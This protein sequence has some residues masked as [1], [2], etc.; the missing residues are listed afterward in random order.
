VG[1]DFV[2]KMRR[3]Y[4]CCFSGSIKYIQELFPERLFI[5]V[6]KSFIVYK[7]RIGR[8]SKDKGS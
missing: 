2:K 8:T 6:H 7:S 1:K 3:E 4:S 5:R